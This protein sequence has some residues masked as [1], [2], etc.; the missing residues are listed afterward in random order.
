MLETVLACDNLAVEGIGGRADFVLQS[1]GLQTQ[2]FV[3][4]AVLCPLEQDC[5]P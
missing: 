4:C 5:D 1:W 3:A 2:S